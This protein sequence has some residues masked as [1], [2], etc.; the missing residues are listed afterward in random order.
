VPSESKSEKSQVVLPPS[1]LVS[2]SMPD[3]PVKK[4]LSSSSISNNNTTL[5]SSYHPFYLV[6]QVMEDSPANLAGLKIGDQV[7]QFGS[8]IKSNKT[9]DAMQQIVSHSIGKP[10]T[11]H[12]LRVGEGIVQLQLIPQHWNGRGL[13]GC[14]L[15]DI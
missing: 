9:G 15:T 10:I 6:D 1:M 12:V 2:P 3:G 13:L 7:I 8:I 4:T 5:L 14:H 11:V